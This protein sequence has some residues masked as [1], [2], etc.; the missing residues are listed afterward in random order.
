M[1]DLDLVSFLEDRTKDN[2]VNVVKGR[3]NKL[4]QVDQRVG[5]VIRLSGSGRGGGMWTVALQ[6][7]TAILS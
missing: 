5:A 1:P 3:G 7:S 2:V 4:R 6:N